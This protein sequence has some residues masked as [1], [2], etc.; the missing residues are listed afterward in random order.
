MK[1]RLEILGLAQEVAAAV[2]DSRELHDLLRCEAE[3]GSRVSG[4][5]EPDDPDPRVQAYVEAKRR[6]ERLVQQVTYVFLFPLTGRLAPTS[7]RPADCDGC[8]A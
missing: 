6:A 2:A 4:P 7:N 5:L 1:T 8:G 3:L